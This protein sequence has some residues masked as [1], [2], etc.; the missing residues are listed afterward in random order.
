VHFPSPRVGYA[1]LTYSG[2][3]TDTLFL[4]KTEDGGANW[5]ATPL[6]ANTFHQIRFFDEKIGL[7]AFRANDPI[8]LTT[9]GGSTWRAHQLSFDEQW[10][11]DIEFVLGDAS[12]VFAAF[13]RNL[14]FSSDTGKTWSPLT[15][16][17]LGFL[18]DIEMGDA[19]HG[20]IGCHYGVMRIRAQ[21]VSVGSQHG[22]G[23]VCHYLLHANRPNPFR[24]ATTIGFGLFAPDRVTLGIYDLCG[25]ELSLL[26]DHCWLDRGHHVFDFHGG[27]LPSGIY[28]YRLVVGGRQT[29]R[30][31]VL[32][33]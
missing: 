27:D 20:W 16:P 8:Y 28:L 30:R 5:R 19:E 33:K 29:T 23:P 26:V 11:D 14:F 3:R 31:M 1:R 18:R 6:A 12:K 32:L 15:V 17:D 9:D 10:V 4:Q 13:G 21:S 7:A 24:Q 2:A 22:V 25:R